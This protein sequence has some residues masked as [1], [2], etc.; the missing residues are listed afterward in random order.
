M[1]FKQY[2][3]ESEYKSMIINLINEDK[4]IMDSDLRMGS[5]AWCA[6]IQVAKSLNNSG[7]VTFNE[8]D[9]SLLSTDLG[10]MAVPE[11][12]DDL[13]EAVVG[14]KTVELDSPKKTP[15]GDK[16]K[17][18]VYVNSGRKNKEGEVIAKLIKWGD[19]NLTVKN[20]IPA[21]AKSFRARHKCDAKT[22]RMTAGWWA[23]NVHKYASQLGL[24]SSAPW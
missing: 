17:Y 16:K 5:D 12:Y 9:K 18:M 22:D 11:K 6:F 14:G 2:F 23:C 3:K 8:N 1:K 19:P 10:T 21:A 15:S 13:F 7:D 20:H 24:Q 4:S